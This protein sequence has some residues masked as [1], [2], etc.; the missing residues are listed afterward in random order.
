M[1]LF[2]SWFMWD[3]S[4]QLAFWNFSRSAQS[5][6]VLLSCQIKRFNK[7]GRT[8]SKFWTRSCWLSRSGLMIACLN[9]FAVIESGETQCL[10]IGYANL[11]Q[12]IYRAREKDDVVMM[13]ER[14]LSKCASSL[15]LKFLPTLTNPIL[16][17]AKPTHFMLKWQSLVV[18]GAK[19]VIEGMDLCDSTDQS[20]REACLASGRKGIQSHQSYTHFAS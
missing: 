15:H 8:R 20:I 11:I 13:S 10:S 4:H 19:L 14:K 18:L 1:L 17:R 6:S 12:Y 2:D 3:R 5:L 16:L 9:V 7:K